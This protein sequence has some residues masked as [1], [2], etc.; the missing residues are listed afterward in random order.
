MRPK[1]HELKTLL[2]APHKELLIVNEHETIKMT[3][4]IAQWKCQRGNITLLQTDYLCKSVYCS[5]H[6]KPALQTITHNHPPAI[7][8][9]LLVSRSPR[10]PSHFLASLAST[11]PCLFLWIT[12]TLINRCHNNATGWMSVSHQMFTILT[13]LLYTFD[14]HNEQTNVSADNVQSG[15]KG[16]ILAEQ[17]LGFSFR[18]HN[19]FLWWP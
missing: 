6:Q 19:S 9:I 8:A 10:Q 2:Q 17:T 5:S 7:D 18:F 12:T 11:N 15:F 3:H 14:S 13:W 4:K 1:L 16:K